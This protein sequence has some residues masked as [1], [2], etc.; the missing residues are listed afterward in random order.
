MDRNVSGPV[1]LSNGNVGA[2]V[3]T[4]CM[5]VLRAIHDTARFFDGGARALA[6]KIKTRDKIDG[7]LVPMNENT[8]TH[9]VNPN[10]F[11]HNVS[12]EEAVE[13]MVKADDFR[14]LHIIAAECGHVAIHVG[15]DAGGATFERVGAMAKE[16]SDV[17]SAVSD[18]QCSASVDGVRVSPNEMARIEREGVELIAALNGLLANIR[19]QAQEV[20][21]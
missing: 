16:F 10:C 1:S 13:M 3:A 15:R 4:H 12:V 2:A 19:A 20:R 8:F 11:S 9:K 7:E 5:G 18:A 6:S 21:H 14:I 17:V